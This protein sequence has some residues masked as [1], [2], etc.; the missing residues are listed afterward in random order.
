MLKGLIHTRC[1][2]PRTAAKEKK[3]LKISER[4]TRDHAFQ[5]AN[6]YSGR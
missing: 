6:A 3:L 2:K 1:F 4:G 5:R